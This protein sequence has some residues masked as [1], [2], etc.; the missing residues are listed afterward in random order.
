MKK[1]G[2]LFEFRVDCDFLISVASESMWFVGM[3][4]EFR[5]DCDFFWMLIKLHNQEWECYLNLEWIATLKKFHLGSLLLWECYLN[6]EW[7]A[8]SKSNA[9]YVPNNSVWECYLNLE[10]IAT[11]RVVL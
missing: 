9:A 5:V 7:I 10:W 11:N 4:F 6:L 1:V 8:T 2:M 3:L